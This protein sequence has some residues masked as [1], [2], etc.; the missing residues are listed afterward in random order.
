MLVA[1]QEIQRISS[2]VFIISQ[3]RR[4][5]FRKRES[6]TGSLARIVSQKKTI[7]LKFWFVRSISLRRRVFLTGAARFARNRAIGAKRTNRF[8]W[9]GHQGFPGLPGVVSDLFMNSRGSSWRSQVVRQS[10]YGCQGNHWI[11]LGYCLR[12][13]LTSERAATATPPWTTQGFCN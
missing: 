4:P 11:L 13:H 9:I 12:H 7:V 3:P 1:K 10:F 8:A 2:H 5:A 6:Q